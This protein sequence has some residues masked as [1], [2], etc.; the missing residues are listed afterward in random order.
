MDIHRFKTS[1]GAVVAACLLLAAPLSQAA[2]SPA[3]SKAVLTSSLVSVTCTL[4]TPAGTTTVPCST[5]GWSPTLQQ[6]WTASMTATYSYAYVDDGLPT[7]T[8][9]S[10]QL[11]ANGLRLQPASFE[12]G[13]LYPLTSGTCASSRY[14]CGVPPSFVYG[15][16]PFAPLFLSNDGVP[17]NTSG[18]V[19]ITANATVAGSSP[20]SWTPRLYIGTF[21]LVN[22]VPAIPEPSTYALMLGGLC[23]V[24]AMARRRAPP[25]V[26][27]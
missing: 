18:T 9:F 17:T 4:T 27:R 2:P 6:G 3:L 24:A 16:T 15:G 7:T 25:S 22:S 20:M 12:A 10:F 19:S 14:G 26:Q 8:P 1:A 23:L 13:A 21:E 11:D 5:T